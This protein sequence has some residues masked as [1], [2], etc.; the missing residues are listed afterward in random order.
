MA[1]KSMSILEI[2]EH[3]YE[4]IYEELQRSLSDL[5]MDK[6]QYK[7]HNQATYIDDSNYNDILADDIADKII[8]K[9]KI[10]KRYQ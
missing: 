7:M 3:V 5:I 8:Q 4:Q 2:E 6:L 10:K 1:K 9:F